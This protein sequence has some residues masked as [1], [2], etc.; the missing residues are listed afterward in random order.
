M[1]RIDDQRSGQEQEAGLE[2][3]L[4]RGVL[5]RKGRTLMVN[6]LDGTYKGKGLPLALYVLVVTW[7]STFDTKKYNTEVEAE[8][9][10]KISDFCRI[11]SEKE[12][13]KAF[14][15]DYLEPYLVV[16]KAAAIISGLNNGNYGPIA[17]NPELNLPSPE[18][19]PITATLTGIVSSSDELNQNSHFWEYVGKKMNSNMYFRKTLERFYEL[20]FSSQN[21]SL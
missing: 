4:D 10:S 8:G 19:K 5:S 14:I 2:Q 17:N 1:D 21:Q 3:R 20:A 15:D 7:D 11:S 12:R 18:V 9:I 13:S 16:Y 6:R